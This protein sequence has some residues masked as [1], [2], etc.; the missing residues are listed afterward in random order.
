MSDLLFVICKHLHVWCVTLSFLFFLVRAAWHLKNSTL[1]E[2]TLVKVAPHIIDT[3]LLLTGV[4]L[5]LSLSLQESTPVWFLL[6]IA[7]IFIYII[8]AMLAFKLN[9]YQKPL[10]ATALSS[11]SAVVYLAVTKPL[12]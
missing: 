2:K 11:F 4:A 10:L 6:K 3:F 8:F 5:A 1:L 12:I 9:T 7:F